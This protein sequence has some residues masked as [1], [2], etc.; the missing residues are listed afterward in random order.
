MDL[1]RD[2]VKGERRQVDNKEL[3]NL[4][5]KYYEGEAAVDEVCSTHGNVALTSPMRAKCPAYLTLI[6]LI[7][8]ITVK[9]TDHYLQMTVLSRKYLRNYKLKC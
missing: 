4:H 6:D 5:T 9:N 2:E 1:K 3:H 7:T 8:Q